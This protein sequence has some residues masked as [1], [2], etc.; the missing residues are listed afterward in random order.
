MRVRP[1][2]W[3]LF[4]FVCSPLSSLLLDE[5]DWHPGMLWSCFFEGSS[6]SCEQPGEHGILLQH[7]GNQRE[8][9][10]GKPCVPKKQTF[11]S[12]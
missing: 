2:F 3:G 8:K 7:E 4:A 11:S 9:K 12:D 1:F 5:C 6:R 10:A